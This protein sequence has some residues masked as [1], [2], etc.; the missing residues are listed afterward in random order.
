MNFL[1]VMKKP[2]VDFA[3]WASENNHVDPYNIKHGTYRLTNMWESQ[4]YHTSSATNNVM[5]HM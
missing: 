2:N 4:S 3:T 1:I 5:K